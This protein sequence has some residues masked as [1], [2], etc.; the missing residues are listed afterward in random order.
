MK[1][2]M[3]GKLKRIGQLT[4]IAL[5]LE[6]ML[7][8]QTAALAQGSLADYERAEGLRGRLEGLAIDI[9]ERPSWI[10][11]TSRLWYRKSV[12]GGHQFVLV[13]AE[14]LEKKPAFDHE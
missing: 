6:T 12:R 2:R 8:P 5:L 3:R 7:L 14:T 11:S 1:N 13:D 10:G 9:P 4:I